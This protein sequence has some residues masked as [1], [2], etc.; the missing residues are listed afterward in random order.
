MRAMKEE[1]LKKISDFIESYIK[2]NNGDSPSLSEIMAYTGMVKSTA[3]R[4]ILELEKR[5]LVSYSGKNTLEIAGQ[6]QMKSHFSRLAVY[7]VIPCGAPEDY[8]QDVEGYLAIPAEWTEG[9]CYLL[10]ATGDSMVDAGIDDGDLVIIKRAER[11]FD[12]QIIAALTEDGTTLKRYRI[13]EDGE[14]FLMAE[15]KSYTSEKRYLYPETI[16]VQGVALKIIKD[17]K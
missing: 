3:Y 8:R 10:R 9:E 1:N 17:A 7:G 16:V 14:A 12:A 11:A 6:E 2:D 15:N 5:G 4:H 13:S